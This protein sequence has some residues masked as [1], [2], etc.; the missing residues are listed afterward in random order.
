MQGI[1]NR[2]NCMCGGGWIYRTL[3]ND[4]VNCQTCNSAAIASA[5]NLEIQRNDKIEETI[6]ICTSSLKTR[7]SSEVGGRDIWV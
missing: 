2:G 4:F 6:L 3:L 7:M 1:N 5:L